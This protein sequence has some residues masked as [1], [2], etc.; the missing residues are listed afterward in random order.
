M[1]KHLLSAAAFMLAIAASGVTYMTVKTASDVVRFDVKEVA[2]VD[3]EKDTVGSKRYMVTK[4]SDEK[5]YKYDVEDVVEVRFDKNIAT[6]DTTGTAAQGTS[7]SGMIAEYT[8]VDLGLGSGLKW[9]TY[10]VGATKPTEYGDYFAWGETEP[11]TSYTWS[12]YK[13]CEGTES[14]LN[15]YTKSGETLSPEDDAATANWGDSWRMPTVAEQKELMDAC[16]WKWT[17]DFQNTGIAGIVGTSKTNKNKIFLPASSY[18][19]DTVHVISK[20]SDAN[21]SSNVGS[22]TT[23]VANVLYYPKEEIK[24]AFSARNLGRNVRAVSDVKI[25]LYTVNFYNADSSLISSQTIQKDEEVIAPKPEKLTGYNFVGWSDSSF[26][27]VKKDLNVYA[28][29][30]IEESHQGLTISGEKGGYYYVDLGLGS[31][32]KWATY[33]VG[34][35]KPTEYGDY[36]AWGETEPKTSYTWSTYK[37]CEGTESSLNKYTKSGETLSPEDDAATANWGDSWR[38]PT[39]AEQKELMDAC[40]WKWTEDFQNTGIAGIVGTSKTNKNMIFL[41]ASSYYDDTVHVTSKQSDAIWSSNTSTQ[42]ISIANVFY[43]T[44]GDVMME[45]TYRKLGRNVRAVTTK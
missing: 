44:K 18:Y 41:P 4:T 27:C 39:V 16:D 24:I 1:K 6:I 9:A 32:L 19:D 22:Q 31:G 35:T 17:E 45:G 26:T 3:Y 2:R 10:N 42:K 5:V 23:V 12:T 15:K 34:A 29:Y 28:Q 14:S 8:Y 7:V 36:F 37:W 25:E 20:P 11:K 38:M 30:K 43:Y 21:W 13:W 33:N 40:D